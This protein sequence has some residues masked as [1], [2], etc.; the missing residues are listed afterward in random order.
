MPHVRRIGYYDVEASSVVEDLSELHLP[1]E[2]AWCAALRPSED[3]LF[4]G[5][6]LIA[7]TWFVRAMCRKVE[8]FG[9]H[10]VLEQFVTKAIRGGRA[11]SRAGDA[12]ARFNFI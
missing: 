1:V 10:V 12:V 5:V 6:D 4:D 2:S 11:G 9:R 7:Q 3:L 8:L